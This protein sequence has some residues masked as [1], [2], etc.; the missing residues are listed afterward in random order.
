MGVVSHRSLVEVE[1]FAV[2]IELYVCLLVQLVVLGVQLRKFLVVLAHDF[3]EGLS[4]FLQ[5]VFGDLLQLLSGGVQAV[6]VDRVEVLHC[7]DK[8]LVLGALSHIDSFK[9]VEVFVGVPHYC[10]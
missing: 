4:V 6:Y 8:V 10:L 3:P 5:S 9:G 1:S 7:L 2:V